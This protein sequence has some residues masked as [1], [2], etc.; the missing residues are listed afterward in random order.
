[1]SFEFNSS[2]V[3][4]K[5]PQDSDRYFRLRAN[6]VKINWL[7]NL[8][9]NDAINNLRSYWVNKSEVTSLTIESS[10]FYLVPLFYLSLVQ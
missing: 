9:I 2:R 8:E 4:R 1:M 7:R 5:W 3:E 6:F 10:I